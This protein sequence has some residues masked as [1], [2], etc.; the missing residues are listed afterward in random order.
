VVDE[1]RKYQSVAI[2]NEYEDMINEMID[3]R[4]HLKNRRRDFYQGRISQSVGSNHY[5]GKQALA[6]KYYAEKLAPYFSKMYYL[7]DF[8]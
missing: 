6:D 8:A 5:L 2:N 7:F 4:P 3:R 1:M